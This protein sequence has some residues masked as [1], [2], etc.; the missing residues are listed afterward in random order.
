M[1][2][3]PKILWID[4]VYGKT[5]NSRNKDRAALCSRLGLKDITDDCLPQA[6]PELKQ[7]LVIDDREITDTVFEEND[8]D[9]VVA[10]VTFCQGQV[11]VSGEVRNDL[12]GTLKVV[13]NGWE[14]SQQ[15]PRWSLLLLDMHF[16]TGTIGE[17]GEPIGKNEDWVPEKYFGLTI[18]DSLWRDPE[19]Q[20]IPVVI[21]SATERDVI[22]RRFTTQGVWAFVD[23]N[24]GLNRAKLKELL[25]DYGLLADKKIIGNSLPLLQGLR[26]AR[27]RARIPNGNILILGESGTG[28]ELLAKYIYQQSGRQ[29]KYVSFSQVREDILEDELS[30]AAKSADGGTLFIDKFDNISA[31]AQAKLSQ[32]LK[33][34]PNRNLQVITAIERED[35]L[36]EDDFCKAL[37]D[38]AQIHNFIRIPTLSQR[39][40]DIPLLVEHFVKKYEEEFDAEPRRVSGE[41]LEA[42]REYP[43]PGNVRELEGVIEDAVFTYKG[44]RWLEAEH[45]K[46]SHETHISPMP[47]NQPNSSDLF[48]IILQD[49]TWEQLRESIGEMAFWLQDT[50]IWVQTERALRGAIATIMSVQFGLNWIDSVSKIID[51]SVSNINDDNDDELKKILN[52][53]KKLKDI[54]KGCKGEQERYLRNYPGENSDLPGLINFTS[55]SDLFKII[56]D[57]DLWNHFREF[58]GGDAPYLDDDPDKYWK[59]YWKE[60]EHIIVFRVRHLM[61]HSNPDLI[62][63]YD[64]DVFKGY[65]GQILLRCQEIETVQ[66]ERGQQLESELPL[67]NTMDRDQEGA[68]QGEGEQEELYE[69]EVKAILPDGVS[70]T[71]DVDGHPDLAWQRVPKEKFQSEEA[72]APGKKVKFKVEKMEQGFQVYDVSLAERE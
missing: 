37:P 51:D 54:F 48:K 72:F 23:K 63:S 41:A 50:A 44:V 16:A 70:A 31:A 2:D 27:R 1:A 7:L 26:E 32:F 67:P 68:E 10:D 57:E 61:N 55:P 34:I 17:N 47:S 56:L 65:C 71:I 29:G 40:G 21:T 6:E 3:K 4:D 12:D 9:E 64:H 33:N 39:L 5:R 62:Q 52:D 8:K 69:G 24:N 53:N 58:F 25:E 59:G 42:L 18:L 15:S 28:K 20:D 30:N 22:E 14:Q 19:L 66:S 60:R 13:R 36:F 46:L 45:L 43:W 38:G 49:D 11:E 35:I